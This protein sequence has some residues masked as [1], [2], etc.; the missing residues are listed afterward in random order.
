MVV[1]RTLTKD[2]GRQPY[3]ISIMKP[4]LA[5]A[6]GT[7]DALDPLPEVDEAITLDSYV[8]EGQPEKFEVI[9]ET[10]FFMLPLFDEINTEPSPSA[11]QNRAAIE[12]LRPKL[13]GLAASDTA[14]QL[15]AP[16]TRLA[17]AL[18]QFQSETQ[19]SDAALD[20]LKTRLLGALPGRL[21]RLNEALSV[22]QEVTLER[23]PERLRARYMAVDG[24]ARVEVFPQEDVSEQA[25]L[26]RFVS[27]VSA[28]EPDSTDDAVTM[29]KAGEVVAGATLEASTL[30]IVGILIVL[31]VV[32][33]SVPQTLLIMVPLGLAAI[34]TIAATVVFQLP[35]NFANV[36]VL[37]LMLG[38]GVDNGIHLVMRYRGEL[39]SNHSVLQTS[40]PRAVLVSA[41]TTMV[42]FGSLAVSPHVGT[43]SMGKLLLISIGLVLISTL[44]VL[45]ALLS[46]PKPAAKPA[47]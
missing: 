32:V 42:S 7:A 14:G 44:V 20:E 41:L 40:T 19:G 11:P 5:A 47:E 8:P 12:A 30:A 24:R 29:V 39:R 38:L 15:A 46:A 2:E 1:L 3:V 34:L 17:D 9:D 35:F 10:A 28:L 37:P 25:A 16:A 6:G 26:E 45:P 43:A 31:V 23:L 13:E 27:A 4:D 36:I 22:E 21:Q 33:G 18:A